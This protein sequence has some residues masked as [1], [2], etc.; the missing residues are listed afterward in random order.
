MTIIN[1]IKQVM[2]KENK[3]LTDKEAYQLI[4]NDNLYEFKAKDP[5]HIV[6]TAIRRHCL[7]LDFPTAKKVKHFVIVDEKRGKSKYFLNDKNTENKI[8]EDKKETKS[9]S[10]KLP[11][12]ILVDYYEKH[13][14]NIKQELLDYILNSEPSF[15]EGLV[16]DL[17]DK[18]GYGSKKKTSIINGKPNDGGIDG[19]I[20][21][22]DLGLEK[23]FVQAKRYSKKSVTPEKVRDFAGA[24]MG[25]QKGVFFTTSKF[26]KNAKEFAKNSPKDIALIDGNMLTDLLISNNLGVTTIK[27]I[28]T[29]QID[30]DYFDL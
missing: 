19:I 5:V 11:E 29:Y 20:F 18:M 6:K 1:A 4:I 21:E 9:S 23:I 10:D 24:M 30:K 25:N 22:D 14:I 17:L 13:K 27:E 15:L 12:E 26:T 2:L 8:F 3:P 28:A 7:G 16:L